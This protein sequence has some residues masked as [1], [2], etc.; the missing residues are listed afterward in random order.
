MGNFVGTVE[1]R[2][3]NAILTTFDSIAVPKTD[4]AIR[5]KKRPQDEFQPMSRKIQ[6]VGN[7]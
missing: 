6:S 5:S 7:A 3:Q 1:D 2:I 4:S